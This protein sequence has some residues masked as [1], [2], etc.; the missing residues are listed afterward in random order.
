MDLRCYGL[1]TARQDGKVSIHLHDLDNFY[2]E[3]DIALLP[4]NAESSIPAG[5]VSD[6]LNELLISS[7][8]TGS[9]SHIPNI[10]P[11]ARTAA[12][13]FLYLYMTISTSDER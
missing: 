13:A 5:E 12:L 4:W 11:A 6:T 1:A 2:H 8:N 10:S 7:L 9:L 3:W